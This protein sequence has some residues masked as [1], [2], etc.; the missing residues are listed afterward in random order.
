[1]LTS[2]P[3]TSLVHNHL[4]F[5]LKI[6]VQFYSQHSLIVYKDSYTLGGG[7]GRVVGLDTIRRLQV[8]TP[9][10]AW[11][12]KGKKQCII[13]DQ[14]TSVSR[15][16][17]SK[18]DATELQLQSCSIILPLGVEKKPITHKFTHQEN[19]TI[20]NTARGISHKQFTH[21]LQTARCPIDDANDFSMMLSFLFSSCAPHRYI[22]TDPSRKPQ[23]RA[24][25]MINVASEPKLWMIIG[26]RSL[27]PRWNNAELGRK[28]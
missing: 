19:I 5:K 18:H 7:G 23:L 8:L 21:C 11:R 16:R 26:T 15:R 4:C 13:N 14:M 1:M 22:I 9:L 2:T 6:E 17:G 3:R 24:V 12:E 27:L 25:C 10:A 28:Q 20:L